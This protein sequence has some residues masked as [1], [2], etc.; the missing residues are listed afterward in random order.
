MTTRT[1]II[2]NIYYYLTYFIPHWQPLKG[3]VSADKKGLP[4]FFF[5][6]YSQITNHLCVNPIKSPFPNI[7]YIEGTLPANDKAQKRYFMFS[8]NQETNQMQ[9]GSLSV[10]NCNMNR[11]TQERKIKLEWS[12]NL[13]GGKRQLQ[14]SCPNKKLTW[15]GKKAITKE[16][17]FNLSS[18]IISHLLYKALWICRLKILMRLSLAFSMCYSC[19]L[20]AIFWLL[21]KPNILEGVKT[22]KRVY[23]S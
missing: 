20:L 13:R 11:H 18:S 1:K 17:Y 16:V 7:Y 10:A 12:D 9:Q 4:S 22:L 2:Y 5:H 14:M 19:Y 21:W 3:C 6:V 8:E 23:H 15:F